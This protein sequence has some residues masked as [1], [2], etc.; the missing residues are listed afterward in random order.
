MS[1]PGLPD[2][3][4][5][6]QI[7]G[8]IAGEVRAALLR[9]GDPAGAAETLHDPGDLKSGHGIDTDAAAVA[10]RV[11]AG[12]GCNLYVEGE[13]PEVA[14]AAPF[15]IYLDPV[16]GSLNWDRGVGDPAFVLAAA[17]GPRAACPDDLRF[18]WVEG[19]RSGDRYRTAAAATWFRAGRSG[20]ERRV[21]TAAPERV[22]EATGYLRAG[23]GGARRQLAHTL[24]LYLAARDLRAIDNA[25]TEFGEVA[26]NAAHFLVEARGLSDGFNLLAWPLVRAA[27]GVL[28]DLEGEDLAARAWRPDAIVD[29]VLAGN[30]RLAG[31][32]VARMRRFAGNG[33]A[34]LEGVMER[35]E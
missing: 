2:D 5:L 27:G 7:A 15:C 3:E 1:T 33:R 32:L 29:Y 35:V 14:A 28:Q 19:L 22:T 17:A 10:R 23:Y 12:L 18:A 16:D 6:A 20:R 21:S 13:P 30:E 34:A 26:R 8:T 24:P 31:D 11:L 4:R 9:R 25:G